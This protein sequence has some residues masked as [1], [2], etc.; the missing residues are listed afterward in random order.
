MQ[1]SREIL[2]EGGSNERSQDSQEA[3][4]IQGSNQSADRSHQGASYFSPN[5]LSLSILAHPAFSSSPHAAESSIPFLHGYSK[6]LFTP[7]QSYSHQKSLS[8][9]CQICLLST[10]QISPSS[11]S[12]SPIHHISPSHTLTP[13]KFP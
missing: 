5:P 13:P 2:I 6:P 4:K 8:P 1:N 9:T 11:T 12:L 10:H 3:Q 7:H